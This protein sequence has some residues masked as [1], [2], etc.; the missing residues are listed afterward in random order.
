[1][2]NVDSLLDVQRL[3]RRLTRFNRSILWGL[4]SAAFL[5]SGI[6]AYLLRFDFSIP[7]S[8]S[9]SLLLTLC[10][11]LVAKAAAF[12]V[13]KLDRGWWQYLT[14]HDLLRL[15]AANLL[16]STLAGIALLLIAPRGVPRSV[17][18][19]DLILSCLFTAGMRA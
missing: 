15:G 9:Q 8:Y 11:W 10:V 3:V 19:L 16:G 2:P 1:M 17:Y 12:R 6:A 4:Q 14:V 7:A 18:V 13:L 5:A